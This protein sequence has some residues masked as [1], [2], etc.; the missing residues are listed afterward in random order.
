MCERDSKRRTRLRVALTLVVAS[1]LI[2]GGHPS[3]IFAQEAIEPA[4][5]SNAEAVALVQKHADFVWT[6]VAAFLVFLMQA[7]FQD[8]TG[9]MAVRIPLSARR[10][11]RKES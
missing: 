8:R 2:I 7:G 1:M 5:A 11:R 3:W 6:L 4:E 9:S 10:C